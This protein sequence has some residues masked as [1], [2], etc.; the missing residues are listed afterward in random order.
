MT[1]GEDVQVA[2]PLGFRLLLFL[3]SPFGLRWVPDNHLG[4]VYRMEMYNRVRG[5][6]FFWIT[7]LIER[8]RQRIRVSPDFMAT[9]IE[10]LQT[11]D[12]VELKVQV[13]LAYTFDPRSLSHNDAV[14]LVSLSRGDLRGIVTDSATWAML[15]ILR[16]YQ[17]EQVCRDDILEPIRQQLL[18]NLFE[19]LNP[20]AMRPVFA[21][22]LTIEP[23]STLGD[24]FTAVANRSAYTHE[25]WKYQD[26]ELAEVRRRE[27]YEVLKKIPGGIRYLSLASANVDSPL[28][29]T[30]EP[31]PYQVVLGTSTSLPPTSHKA[32][33][34]KE[35]PQGSDSTT[36]GPLPPPA[37]S[38]PDS[39]TK[40]SEL[41]RQPGI[42]PKSHLQPL[43][44]PPSTEPDAG[45]PKT[46]KRSGISRKSHLSGQ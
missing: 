28:W 24:T 2:P 13:A 42:S 38:S 15:N 33:T 35:A 39:D 44:V 16:E 25:I 20:L 17:A 12:G 27:L 3:A 18:S 19:L 34:D 45:E 23:P 21:M 41:P 11:Q 5:P 30:E 26:F 9:T 1:M 6:G 7:P 40:D 29:H 22:V 43:P 14:V 8:V 31:T 4:A 46:P 10:N 32:D 36:K 37:S